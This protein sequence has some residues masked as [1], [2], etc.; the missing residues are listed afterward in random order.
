MSDGRL[1]GAIVL[2]VHTIVALIALPFSVVLA[3]Y[4]PMLAGSQSRPESPLVVMVMLALLLLSLLLLVGP[5][6]AWISWARRRARA[7]CVYALLPL[8]YGVLV[9]LA[10]N[11]FVG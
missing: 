10:L 7:A 9:V 2:V 6:G 3:L 8:V 5:I 11:V 4:A 1:L